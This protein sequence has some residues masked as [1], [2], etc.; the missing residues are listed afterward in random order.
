M[1]DLVLSEKNKTIIQTMTLIFVF[2]IF[3]RQNSQIYAVPDER[4]LPLLR[5]KPLK[6]SSEN[7]NAVEWRDAN[8]EDCEITYWK[9]QKKR[10]HSVRKFVV[11]RLVY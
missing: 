5:T 1:K 7:T 10:Q 11:Q 2:I 9:K 8:K 6:Q 4:S 3:I